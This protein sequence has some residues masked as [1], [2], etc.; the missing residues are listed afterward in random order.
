MVIGERSCK[1]LLALVATALVFILAYQGIALAAE[2]NSFSMVTTL[3]SF[4]NLTGLMATAYGLAAVT[5]VLLAATLV[6]VLHRC[7]AAVRGSKTDTVLAIL[8]KYTINTGLLTSVGSVL[9]FIF[10]LAL[11]GNFIYCG[12]SIIGTRLYANSVIAMLNSR[13]HMNEQLMDDFTPSDVVSHPTR[14]QREPSMTWNSLA[15][16]DGIA[17][18]EGEGDLESLPSPPGS[19]ACLLQRQE[20]AL[21]AAVILRPRHS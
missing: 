13:H 6:V 1:R 12:F 3:A 20:L 7:R 4:Y 2:V 18:R 5:D 16:G 14:S 9:A 8:I 15:I 11:P 10:V 17:S 19:N 21:A